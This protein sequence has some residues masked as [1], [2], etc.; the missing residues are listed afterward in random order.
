MIKKIINE[1]KNEWKKNKVVTGFMG[2]ILALALLT[3]LKPSSTSGIL[4][5]IGIT[6]INFLFLAIVLAIIWVIFIRKKG[7]FKW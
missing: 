7:G 1:I 4:N 6:A 3:Y 5:Y 2:A